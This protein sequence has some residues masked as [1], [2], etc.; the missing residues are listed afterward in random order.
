MKK[1]GV[2]HILAGVVIG[3]FLFTAVPA[4]AA[5]VTAVISSQ[6]VTVDGKP[7]QVTAYNIDG[8]NYFKL[9]DMAAILDVGVWF[10]AAANTVRIEPDKKY[11]PNYTG[12]VVETKKEGVYNITDYYNADGKFSALGSALPLGS[13][14]NERA[15]TLQ[16]GDIIK[17][18]DKQY[19][20][21]ADSLTL[22]FYT[23]PSHEKVIV[24]WT[25]Y[26]DSCNESGGII[27]VK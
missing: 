17:V 23:Q 1:S 8:S 15:L 4:I 5:G 16:N 27:E 21:T 3:A 11:D 13:D 7:V 25:D 26:M 22:Y 12:P 2:M 24:W 9:R 20:V 19:K 18:G 10:D 14:E 6:P